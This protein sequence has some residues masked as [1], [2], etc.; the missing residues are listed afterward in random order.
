MG[1]CGDCGGDFDEGTVGEIDACEADTADAGSGF[2][3]GEETGSSDGSDIGTITIESS[4]TATNASELSGNFISETF[5]DETGNRGEV[6]LTDNAVTNETFAPIAQQ[7]HEIAFN[8]AAE[9]CSDRENELTA[10]ANQE[11]INSSL[12]KIDSPTLLGYHNIRTGELRCRDDI[13]EK[14][15][16]HVMIH[17]NMHSASY[18]SFEISQT[19]KSLT[20]M[21]V[22]GIR[23]NTEIRCKETG[24]V[25]EQFSKN[26][27]LNEG[28][29]EEYSLRAELNNGLESSGV[30]AY[31]ANRGYAVQLESLVGS[32]M[33]NEAY[34]NGESSALSN[35]VNELG[36]SDSTW[37][38]FN[39]C[40]DI[41]CKSGRN[42]T[43]E[44]LAEKAEAQE[45]LDSIIEKM[46]ISKIEEESKNE[47][48]D[49]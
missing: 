15:A 38:D 5:A 35:R 49:I 41:V 2:D 20:E 16:S 29:T 11:V 44:Q 45:R 37:N 27:G 28:I 4:D 18:Q 8:Y 19:D 26:V 24:Q 39:N 3:S 1:D 23:E 48:K 34:F 42:M 33:M 9:H 30:N 40:L 12:E 46:N 10:K 32:E 36:K 31:S 25:L 6:I 14:A 13:T 17:E 47:Y 22:S 21:R 7:S 43:E